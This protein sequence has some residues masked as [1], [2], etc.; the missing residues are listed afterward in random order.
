MDKDDGRNR[1]S[2][3]NRV[4]RERRTSV[5]APRRKHMEIWCLEIYTTSGGLP[6]P[7]TSTGLVPGPIL[8]LMRRWRGPG[9][10]T[11]A[12]SV[13][14]RSHLGKYLG[15]LAV[16]RCI[17]IH[18]GNFGKKWFWCFLVAYSVTITHDLW[19]QGLSMYRSPWSHWWNS[20][21]RKHRRGVT[22]VGD[23]VE[24]TVSAFWN[25]S[26]R[27]RI[28]GCVLRC[29]DASVL[30]APAIDFPPPAGEN[31]A[32]LRRKNASCRLWGVLGGVLNL[33]LR[34]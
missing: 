14:G 20:M 10:L 12:V 28:S 4:S 26:H 25:G 9:T 24:P 16:T 18:C 22:T 17:K 13:S 19:C 2:Q 15:N 11:R 30:I 29:G 32:A 7:I 31:F 27:A 3:R 33:G 23:L 6:Q 8:C 34:F 1:D 5:I 21:Q